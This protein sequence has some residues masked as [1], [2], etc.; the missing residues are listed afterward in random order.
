M[1]LSTKI[2]SVPSSKK[3]I[4]RSRSAIFP[5]SIPEM[6]ASVFPIT[7]Q[8]DLVNKISRLFLAPPFPKKGKR[9]AP[10]PIGAAPRKYSGKGA[11][12]K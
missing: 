12:D 4:A 1:P 5:I 6:P 10:L 11:E 8:Q 2:R 7:S 9:G 3:R